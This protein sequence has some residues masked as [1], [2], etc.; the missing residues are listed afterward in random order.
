MTMVLVSRSRF[1]LTDGISRP[2]NPMTISR[3]SVARQ[4]SESVKRSPPTGSMTTSTPTP[5]VSRDT[6]SRSR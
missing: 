1:T 5:L 2:V 3:P 6:C 4:R